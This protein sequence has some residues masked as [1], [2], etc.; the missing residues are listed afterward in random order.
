MLVNAAKDPAVTPRCPKPRL[1]M[2]LRVAAKVVVH[3]TVGTKKFQFQ[4]TYKLRDLV[5]KRRFSLDMAACKVKA[6]QK[7]PVK[8][9]A[10][11]DETVLRKEVPHD[12]N[13]SR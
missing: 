10:P 5:I 13:C 8:A 7:V 3:A 4:F 9:A 2:P 12:L 11:S 1:R 6:E